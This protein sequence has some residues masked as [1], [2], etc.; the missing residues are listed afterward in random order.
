MP[1]AA[2]RSA[3]VALFLCGC[4]FGFTGGGLPPTIRT[5]AVTPFEN[6]TSD[7]TIAQQVDL[8]V[9]EAMQRRLGLRSAAESQ[10]DAVVRGRITRYLPDEPLA[11]TGTPSATPGRST[12]T[13]QVTKRQV[14][15][16]IDIE[17]VEQESG[18]TL[19]IRRALTRSGEYDPGREAEGRR[20]ALQ[21]LV[22]DIVDGAQSQW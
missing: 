3:A 21:L 13:V 5:V 20:K 19:W 15:V 4:S 9:R 18:R 7:P 17:I 2:I 8:A 22:N 12:N 16:T 14:Q 10:A 1:R 11:Y 6:D